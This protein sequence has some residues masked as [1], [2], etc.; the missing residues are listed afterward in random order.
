MAAP[1]R[2]HTCERTGFFPSVKPR[3]VPRAAAAPQGYGNVGECNS[4]S[5]DSGIPAARAKPFHRNR[6]LPILDVASNV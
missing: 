6:L 3:T 2:C 5:G 1:P 4:F